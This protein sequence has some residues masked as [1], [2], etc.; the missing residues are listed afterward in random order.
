MGA[1]RRETLT[2]D[3][4]ALL[5]SLREIERLLQFPSAPGH[6]ERVHVLAA[7]I[8]KQA[9][10]T[11][12]SDLAMK[13]IGQAAKL[14]TAAAERKDLNHTLWHLRIALQEA[15]TSARAAPKTRP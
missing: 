6:V 13:L 15:K 7:A 1:D 4:E 10:S 11:P 9:P 14:R 3:F 2:P 8:A 12:V 5:T